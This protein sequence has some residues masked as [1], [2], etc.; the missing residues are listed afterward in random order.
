MIHVHEQ[1][2]PGIKRRRP[3]TEAEIADAI[4]RLPNALMS[5]AELRQLAALCQP[6]GKALEIGT[7]VGG[8]AKWLASVAAKVVTIDDFSGNWAGK[9]KDEVGGDFEQKA[10][11]NLHAELASGKIRIIKGNS[12]YGRADVTRQ[13]AGE[14]F[15]LAFID[16][17]H[18]YDHVAND[19]DLALQHLRPGGVIAGH[20]Y[21]FADVRR[22][23]DEKLGNVESLEKLWW[24]RLD[25]DGA[26]VGPK[27][28]NV[29]L[30][31]DG[32]PGDWLM[33]T[34][35]CE[36][37][38]RDHPYYRFRFGGCE[39]LARGAPWSCLCNPQ[40]T[41]KVCYG[42]AINRSSQTD[43]RFLPAFYEDLRD[44]LGLTGH[45]KVNQPHL[46]LSPW[47][48]QLPRQVEGDYVVINAGYKTAQ[49]VKHWGHANYQAV[50]DWIMRELGLTVVQIGRSADRHRPLTGAVNLI[51]QTD[52]R[53]F[54]RLAYYAKLGIGP[55][56][57]V[58]HVFASHFHTPGRT[59][60]RQA[61]PF[62]CL[63]SGWNPK[64][65]A[66]YN[67]EVYLSR[68]GQLAC[69]PRSQGCWRS[70]MATCEHPE[71]LGDEQIP[72]CLKMIETADVIR[73]IKD[74]YAGGILT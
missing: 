23:V 38:W 67:S 5:Q 56:S 72:R 48:M 33:L 39:E 20:D 15:D 55:E 40:Q 29:T 62:V 63:A 4:D 1:L 7:F 47:E 21:D 60:D 22:A 59:A 42:D 8:S 16:A 49:E 27:Q 3:A 74:Y 13:L 54:V 73:A 25:G 17:N 28:I 52:L 6:R 53:Q 43:V 30:H 50:A 32:C 41:V 46:Y 34:A 12:K 35:A 45:I 11:V 57:F 71:P 24:K 36:S 37:I 9:A 70:T 14:T 51:D 18:E 2:A 61:I 58:H 26:T 66:S 69:C 10:R 19:I 65:W 31:L 68:Q 64:G 44:K